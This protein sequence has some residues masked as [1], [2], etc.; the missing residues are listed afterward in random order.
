[1]LMTDQPILVGPLFPDNVTG[2]IATLNALS[3]GGLISIYSVDVSQLNTIVEFIETLMKRDGI[4]TEQTG[5]PRRYPVARFAL[6][7]RAEPQSHA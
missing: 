5:E 1:M 6:V 4:Y 3:N 2:E 7:H